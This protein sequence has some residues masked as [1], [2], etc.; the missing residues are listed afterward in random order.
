[1]F[2]SRTVDGWRNIGA[3]ATIL[4]VEMGDPIDKIIFSGLMLLGL[5]ALMRRGINW[6]RFFK[7]NKWIFIWFLF[8]G[9]SILWSDFPSV[10]AKRWIKAVGTLIMAMIVVTE[11]EDADGLGTIIRRCAYILLP[12]SVVFI[13]YFPEFGAV[14]YS[15]WGGA[16]GFAGV[17]QSKNH[18]GRLCMISGLYFFWSAKK[19]LHDSRGLAQKVPPIITLIIACWLL[20]KAN[21]Q[22]PLGGFI[23]GIFILIM[24]GLFQ[25]W[26]MS[27]MFGKLIGVVI[28]I[29]LFVEFVIGFNISGSLISGLGRD[30]TLTGRTE[31]WKEIWDMGK[32]SI[33]G[34]GYD[35]FWLGERLWTLWEKHWWKPNEAHN[36][37]LEIYLELGITGLFFFGMMLI[38]TYRKIIKAMKVNFDQGKFRMAIFMMFILFNI[39]E[40]AMKGISVI[41]TMFLF[42]ALEY[43]QVKIQTNKGNR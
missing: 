30:P 11:A 13:K 8:C 41:W 12:L 43:H 24:L 40:T 32:N 14:Q 2:A 36:G 28:I 19:M 31:L 39:T 6:S 21:S 35:S 34:V 22:T 20:V 42:V 17:T 33:I 1:M 9:L 10:A 27:H 5:V 15:P 29:F 4:D 23:A 37:Y 7:A 38:S 3:D 26:N 18:L 16:A 25:K